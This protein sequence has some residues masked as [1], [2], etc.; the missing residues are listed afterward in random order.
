[1]AHNMTTDNAWFE[2][3]V[4]REHSHLNRSL[5]YSAWQKPGLKNSRP[6]EGALG[7][8]QS[9]TLSPKTSN[10]KPQTTPFCLASPRGRTRHQ[11]QRWPR[12]CR[13]A[14]T[15]DLA[16][17]KDWKPAVSRGFRFEGFGQ[18]FKL[19]HEQLC[20]KTGKCCKFKPQTY[21]NSQP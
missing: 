3:N 7:H 6:Q 2:T 4:N 5:M 21:L 1:M 11:S 19:R 15:K 12:Q 18:A 20:Q 16:L 14:V 17:Y 13:P 10:S 9:S 8:A